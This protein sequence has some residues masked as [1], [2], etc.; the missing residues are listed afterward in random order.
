LSAGTCRATALPNKSPASQGQPHQ[1]TRKEVL[2]VQDECPAPDV[3]CMQLLLL[4]RHQQ[5]LAALLMA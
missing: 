2:K 3:T 4:T 1:H 5:L